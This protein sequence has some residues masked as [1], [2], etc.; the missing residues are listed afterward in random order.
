MKREWQRLMPTTL[1]M[2]LMTHLLMLFLMMRTAAISKLQRRWSALLAP[3][4]AAAYSFA[5]AC[6]VRK[7]ERTNFFP[8]CS[9]VAPDGDGPEI[10]QSTPGRVY[11][12]HPHFCP[13]QI[14]GCSTKRLGSSFG[15]AGCAWSRTHCAEPKQLRRC[16]ASC[17]P[18]LALAPSLRAD[19][20]P[21]W[22]EVC[23]NRCP[24]HRDIGICRYQHG[25]PYA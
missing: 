25:L 7:C 24:P 9:K 15:R 17:P 13:L 22:L 10:D 2:L 18:P 14:P 23:M 12:R 19:G 8:S 3:P 4:R 20:V 11:W 5:F 21:S 1:P 16:S 6:T